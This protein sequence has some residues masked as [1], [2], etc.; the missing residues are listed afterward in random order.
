MAITT[1]SM[2]LKRWDQPNDLFSYVELSDNFATIDVHDHSTGKGVQIPAAGIQNL[3]IDSTKLANDAVTNTKI[4]VNTITGDRVQSAT[5][6]DTKLASPNNTVYRHL[7]VANA[8]VSSL[9]SA[10]TYGFSNT[11]V[12][13]ASGVSG[14]VNIP[15]LLWTAADYLVANKNTRMRLVVSIGVNTVAP[16]DTLTFGLSPVSAVGGASGQSSYTLGAHVT[17]STVAFVTPAAN[18]ATSTSGADFVPPADG[19]YAITVIPTGA[20]AAGSV[21]TL[22]A[23]FQIHHV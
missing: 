23:S 10:T 19:R 6:A 15:I 8:A 1:P 7:Y 13:V 22:T 2:G 5:L 12:A 20:Q 4:P 14:T 16:T 18:V 9:A 11:G 17:G 21:V 3:S